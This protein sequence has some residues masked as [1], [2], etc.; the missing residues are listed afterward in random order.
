MGPSSTAR[1]LEPDAVPCPISAY[2]R[3]KLAAEGEVRDF[4]GSWA[5]VRPPAIYGPRDTDI[6][7]FFRLASRGMLA[8]PSGERWIT[9]AFVADV[10]EAVIAAAA[11]AETGR[12][13]HIGERS[14][15]RMDEMLRL[16]A[17]GG[18]VKARLL[19]IPPLV[20]RTAG[21]SASLLRLLGMRLPLSLDKSKEILA[22]HWTQQTAESHEALGIQGETPF[23]DGVGATWAWYRAMGW[24]P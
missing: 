22:R 6:F 10:V 11:G 3:S 5:I 4:T 24:L 19:R 21:A 16:I 9:V 20:F 13:Y 12:T 18:G 1:G 14:P 2:G 23:A 17:D 8:M 7:E 15:Y